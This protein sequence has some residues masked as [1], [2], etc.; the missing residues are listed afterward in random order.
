MGAWFVRMSLRYG[1]V[2]FISAGRRARNPVWKRSHAFSRI[3]AGLTIVVRARGASVFGRRFSD[4]RM[5]VIITPYWIRGLT[6]YGIFRR[7]TI[8]TR[9]F[10][11]FYIVAE[12]VRILPDQY[13]FDW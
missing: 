2:A 3:V 8:L 11:H 6:E 4:V 10:F 7:R 13:G 5:T 9:A 1:A 12:T